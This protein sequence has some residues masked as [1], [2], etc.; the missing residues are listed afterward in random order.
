MVH[1]EVFLSKRLKK[2]WLDLRHFC[3]KLY[4]SVDQP[5]VYKVLL[6][7]ISVSALYLTKIFTDGIRRSRVCGSEGSQQ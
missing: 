1:F 3:A 7:L 5:L 4:S 2:S 6:K